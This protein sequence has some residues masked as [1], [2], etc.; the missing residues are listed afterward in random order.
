[1]KKLASLFI[2]A[3]TSAYA[4]VPISGL[5][6]ASTP[7]QGADLFAI[8]QNSVTKKA[9]LNNFASFI[10]T[11]ANTWTALQNIGTQV[12]ATNNITQQIEW[13][14]TTG[15][16]LGVYQGQLTNPNTTKNPPIFVQRYLRANMA[17]EYDQTVGTMFVDTEIVGS[18]TTTPNYGAY[19]GGLFSTNAINTNR[20]TPSAPNFDFRG[21]VIGLAGF[22]YNSG[23]SIGHITTALWGWANGPTLDATTYANLV[24]NF[25][26]AGLEINL[27]YNHPDPTTVTGI[28]PFI[29]GKG[30][31]V[32]IFESNYR[33]PGSGVKDWTFG[34]VISGVPDTNNY[35]DTNPNNWNGVHTGI[36]VDH[37][38]DVAIQF[39]AYVNAGK[40]LLGAPTYW[41]SG[42]ADPNITFASLQNS[43]INMGNFTGATFAASDFWAN[44]NYLYFSNGANNF[45]MLSENMTG[46]GGTNKG[47]IN[48][49]NSNNDVI[50]NVNGGVPF[51]IH[52]VASGLNYVDISN[53]AAGS[54][55]II[56]ALGG[57]T[58]VN[59]V[60]T[61]KGAGIVSATTPMKAG[62]Y[63]IAGLPTCNASHLG[64]LA[65]VSDGTAYA[66]GTY[67][68]AV[69]ATGAVTRSVFC[70]NTGGPTT[71]AWA[72]N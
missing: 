48:F 41:N 32:G 49:I 19:K 36:L 9:T 60:L 10:L 26:T 15:T 53:A 64:S 35:S 1:M 29:I 37:V 70:T 63:T 14:T 57:D 5:P 46:A 43:K 31:S 61:P 2:F 21:D 42:A 33:A 25:T 58:N 30:A 27:T 8:V 16:Q 7:L 66:T 38:K 18:G 28:T 67:G 11:S 65:V 45:H 34:Q 17:G 69:S 59:L 71:Y 6:T 55:P 13:F 12:G 68:S 20:G 47:T 4:Q 23:A 22:A 54:G 52:S 24:G 56:K 39:G 72:Y 62:T 3:A 40:V 50:F 51:I 44:S